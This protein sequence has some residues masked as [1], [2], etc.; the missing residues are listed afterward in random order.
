MQCDMVYW[1]PWK[2]LWSISPGS[3]WSALKTR[4]VIHSHCNIVQQVLTSSVIRHVT[5]LSDFLANVQIMFSLAINSMLRSQCKHPTSKTSLKRKSKSHCST[6]SLHL[7]NGNPLPIP[8]T[9]QVLHFVVWFVILQVSQIHN[10]IP[11]SADKLVIN[12]SKSSIEHVPGLHIMLGCHQPWLEQV[13][14]KTVTQ[15]PNRYVLYKT[16]WQYIHNVNVFVI[17]TLA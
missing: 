11:C 1:S 3:R 15:S 5:G 10:A 14:I 17:F 6:C 12:C 16:S 2:L 13:L 8:P 7:W 4:L 9:Y